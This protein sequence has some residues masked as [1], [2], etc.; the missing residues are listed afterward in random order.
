VTRT[1]KKSHERRPAGAVW[2]GAE[3]SAWHVPP[4]MRP[5]QWAE[6]YRVIHEGS[7]SIPGPYRIDNAPYQRGMMDI[8]TRPGCVRAVCMK[9]ARIGWSEVLRN[10]IGYWAH[11][12][13]RP[14]GLAL[15]SRDEGR[16]VTKTEILPM[17]RRTPVL[18]KL[19]GRLARDALI[20]SIDL[21]NGF[22]LGLMWSGSSA[23]TAGKL[24]AACIV[25]E[26][27]K[28]EEWAGDEPDLIGRL[29]SRISTYR[30]RRLLLA[31]S[32]PTT[33]NGKVAQLMA[34][35]S[36][37][38]HFEVPCPHC[39]RYQRLSWPQFRWAK[40]EDVDRWIKLAREAADGGRLE[41]EDDGHVERFGDAEHLTGRIGWLE[42]VKRRMAAATTKS[43]MADV[44]AFG[45]EHL[46]WY[47]C[48]YC[49]GRVADQ[50][51]TSMIRRGRWT[52]EGGTVTD[53]WG[54]EHEDAE[55]VERWP[56][57]TRIGFQ[58]ATWYS[59]FMHWG[60]VVAEFLRAEGSLHRT[61]NWRTE[62][63]GEPFEFRI[64]RAD[65]AIF[66]GKV[67]RATLPAGV[68]PKWGQLLLATIDT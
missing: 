55:A 2:D 54:N 58:I 48:L 27:D 9:G 64:S 23:S 11:Y 62:R 41:Y 42:E 4:P 20:E 17:F 52:G 65:P 50:D 1:A 12:D 35:C 38:L 59:L 39:G 15:P 32:T 51:K 13:P 19:I 46:I 7:S 24:Y 53:Y 30:D 68:V 8:P 26:V 60:T 49:K 29:E 43:R 67:Q 25:D 3:R 37:R 28:T 63:A 36:V 18:R 34:E 44:L 47:Q 22:R 5:S 14:V 6:R 31:G 10:L 45:R 66:A 16:K 61:F 56:N 21:L 40:P 57:E 33:A